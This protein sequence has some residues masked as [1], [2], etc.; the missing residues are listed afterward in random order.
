MQ[1]NS[2]IEFANTLRGFAAL[3]VVISH[4]YGVFWSNRAAVESITNAPALPL[5]THAIRRT[6]GWLGAMHS[7]F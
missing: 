7:H 6:L 1:E 5:E 2:R 3:A 4:Y